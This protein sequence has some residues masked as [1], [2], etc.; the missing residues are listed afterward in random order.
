M[1][2]LKV[3]FLTAKDSTP[4]RRSVLAIST[5]GYLWRSPRATTIAK[6]RFARLRA[7][8]TTNIVHW[9][10][11]QL[12]GDRSVEASKST[13]LCESAVASCPCRSRAPIRIHEQTWHRGMY[14]IL[15]G[16]GR[17]APHHRYSMDTLRRAKGEKHRILLAR[18]K[19]AA[20]GIR[21]VHRWVAR[22][23]GNESLISIVIRKGRHQ[24]D[25]ALASAVHNC[26]NSHRSQS[27]FSARSQ[28]GHIPFM[29]MLR[30]DRAVEEQHESHR[31]RSV[32][33]DTP[34]CRALAAHNEPLVLF[35]PLSLSSFDTRIAMR[36]SSVRDQSALVV[37]DDD[38]GGRASTVARVTIS[39]CERVRTREQPISSE[40]GRIHDVSLLCHSL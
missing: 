30:G 36:G 6:P 8:N 26:C 2:S 11:N 15:L 27:R 17:F 38:E 5:H 25:P 34:L 31:I 12:P 28:S 4:S 39:P 40:G 10:S 1:E 7:S 37:H 32:R 29:L 33:Q 24:R 18:E 22:S 9:L 35:L 20:L 13:F 14:P 19:M 23:H 3:R 16:S 21:D